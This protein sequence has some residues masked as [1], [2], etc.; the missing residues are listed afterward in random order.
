MEAELKKTV[1]DL[2]GQI[3][4]LSSAQKESASSLGGKLKSHEAE[5]STATIELTTLRTELEKLKT[6]LETVQKNC[7]IAEEKYA[8][9]MVLHA[10]DIQVKFV[11]L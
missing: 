11:I 4:T 9:E 8:H 1:N 10:K 3:S 7:Q 2:Q 5:L 6:E